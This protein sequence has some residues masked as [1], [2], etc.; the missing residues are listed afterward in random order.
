MFVLQ[1]HFYV[2][3]D[4]LDR[5]ICNEE[6]DKSTETIKNFCVYI[7]S[8]RKI[9]SNLQQQHALQVYTLI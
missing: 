7:T 2:L 8:A 1:D 9:R 6:K 4:I 3:G 5:I